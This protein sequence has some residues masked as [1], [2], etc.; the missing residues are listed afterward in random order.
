MCWGM[1]PL[2]PF[3]EAVR[4]LPS[5]LWPD[6]CAGC[7]AIT[8]VPFR[9]PRVPF[10]DPCGTSL[11]P[12]AAGCPVC[13]EPGDEALLPALRPRR[14]GHCQRAPPFFAK[15]SAP[16]LHGGALAEAIH[17]LKYEKRPELAAPLGVLFAGADPPRADVV[18]PIPLHPSRLRW[19]GFDQADLLARHAAHAFALPLERL[20]VR[21]RATSQQVSQKRADRE[22]NLRGAFRAAP[23][24]AGRAVCLIDDVLTTGAT[25]NAAAA[26]LKEAGA[27]RVEVRTLARAAA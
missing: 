8:R 21:I 26:A 9:N 12:C 18:A 5:L 25:A 10:C 13:G 20:L 4:S 16:W 2:A 23:E 1:S 19:R 6:R 11:V 27:R 17:K 22:R 15:A 7:D 3:L 14:C 24:A